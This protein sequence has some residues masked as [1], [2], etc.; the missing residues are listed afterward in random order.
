MDIMEEKIEI[1]QAKIARNV[2]DGQITKEMAEERCT[3]MA[4]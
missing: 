2:S 4:D 3:E 1:V